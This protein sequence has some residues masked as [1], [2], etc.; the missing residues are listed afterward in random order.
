MA[1]RVHDPAALAAV[2]RAPGPAGPG[3]AGP[4]SREGLAAEGAPAAESR[5]EAQRLSQRVRRR[6]WACY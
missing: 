5:W 6:P 4:Q 1:V 2:L 3:R